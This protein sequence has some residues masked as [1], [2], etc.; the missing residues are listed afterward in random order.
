[1][2]LR[3]IITWGDPKLKLESKDIVNWTPELEQLVMDLFETA[4]EVDGVG[5][6]APQVGI[7]L[8]IAVVDISCGND[9]NSK[10]VLINPEITCRQG[11]QKSSE[12]CL[13]VPG[14]YEILDRPKQIWVKNRKPDGSWEEFQ[15]KDLLARTICHEV[16]H[17]RGV[18]FFEY[19]GPV[20][21]QIIQ[22]RYNKQRSH[23]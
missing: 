19:F 20:K 12:G 10:I 7:N 18:L 8:N 1:M 23:S 5:L 22:R 4:L 16:D 17:L 6:A 21:R 13:S 3:K 2:T 9:P 15:G 14:I 11:S